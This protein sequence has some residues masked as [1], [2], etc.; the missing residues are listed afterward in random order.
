M[1]VE[2]AVKAALEGTERPP[3]SQA[4]LIKWA[5]KGLAAEAANQEA[6]KK[7]EALTKEVEELRGLKTDFDALQE[8]DV[9]AF[10]RLGAKAGI[11]GDY[12]EEAAREVFAVY[13]TE[14][15]E[16]DDDSDPVEEWQRQRKAQ[17][18]EEPRT[19]GY[20]DLDP[21]MRKLTFDLV[22][23]RT[24]K[25]L[26]QALDT[27][28]VIG[29]YLKNAEAKQADA[30]RSLAKELLKGQLA[31]EKGDFTKI[32]EMIPAV[33]NKVRP[34]VESFPVARNTTPMGLGP[35]PGS[36]AGSDVPTE[37]PKHVSSLAGPGAF[38]THLNEMIAFEMAK[39]A[40]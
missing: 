19:V 3:I 13:G 20:R 25:A 28:K 1:A 2:D 6:N 34:S 4:D 9:D 12:V 33:L 38:G 11:P 39:E 18:P 32:P 24:D 15:D 14:E 7:M 31:V 16:D 26:Q 8:G 21:E 35:A 30:V 22:R 23:E 37:K 29:Y 27:D 5:Q 40:S 17:E 10:R 36:G